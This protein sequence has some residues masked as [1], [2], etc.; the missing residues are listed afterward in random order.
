MFASR[1]IIEEI[2]KVESSK[3]I[4]CNKYVFRDGESNKRKEAR[5]STEE[6][7]RKRKDGTSGAKEKSKKRKNETSEP[8]GKRTVST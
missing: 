3:K 8:E 2:W 6:G 5:A 4:I 1:L 7:R